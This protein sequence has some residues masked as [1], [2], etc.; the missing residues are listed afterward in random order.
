MFQNLHLDQ[1]LMMESLFISDDLD[2][3]VLSRLV[4]QRSDHLSEASLPDHLQYL[5]SEQKIIG[6]RP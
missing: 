2:G 6:F 5:V 1:R 4:I 3:N